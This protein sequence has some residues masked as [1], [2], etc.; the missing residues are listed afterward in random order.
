MDHQPLM[1]GK[2]CLVTGASHGIGKETAMGLAKLGA[3]VV[4]IC[5]DTEPHDVA[6]AESTASEI[7]E[8]TGSTVELI[9]ADL[10]SQSALRDAAEQFE[11]RY[12]HLDVLVNNAG[13][14][15]ESRFVTGDGLERTFAT[16]YLAQF[17]LSHL[18]QDRLR[19]AGSARI[20]NVSSVLH[21]V[22]RMEFDDLQAEKHYCGVKAYAQSK[23]ACVL[24]TYQL[25][26][27]LSGVGITA[28][29]LHPG[30]VRS[31]FGRNNRGWIG[32][33]A[34]LGAP[35]MV[36]PRRGARTSIY[37]ASSPEVA[38]VTGRYFVR[39]RPKQSSRASY[40]TADGERLWAVSAELCA[41]ATV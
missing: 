33:A 23:L 34:R 6:M 5:R 29:C 31:G 17:L 16:N 30:I 37:L 24:F 36:S 14:V 38:G 11:R 2:T 12:D 21:R 28:N 22:G 3:T 13:A 25:A 10:A 9:S 26:K 8:A 18:L 7:R 20:V 32:V 15:Y 4:L 39:R 1:A 19:A 27:R 35:F 41:L 40:D